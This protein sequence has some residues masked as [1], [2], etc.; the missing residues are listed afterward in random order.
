[1]DEVNGWER[2][3]LARHG[4]TEWNAQGRQQGQLDSPLTPMGIAQ[5]RGH[6]AALRG[7]DVDIV[8]TSPLGRARSTAGIIADELGLRVI[9]IDD[10]AEVHHGRFAGLSTQDIARRYPEELARRASDKYHWSFPDGESYA[11]ADVRAGLALKAI[12]RYHAKRP[13][14]VAHEMIS[15]MLQRHLLGLE[16][17]QA[18]RLGHPN[19]VIYV[20]DPRSR[21]RRELGSR[22]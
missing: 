2:V 15:R 5:A 9:V 22:R 14:L 17:D 16:P 11:D 21:T 8:F 18:L 12:S 19:N 1:M 4:Q 6:A 3:Y 20:L 7:E 13:V 10:L